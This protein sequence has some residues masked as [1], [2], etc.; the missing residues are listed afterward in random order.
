MT[1]PKEEI[2]RLVPFDPDN[3]VEVETLLQQ[4]IV[5]SA[6]RRLRSPYLTILHSRCLVAMRV[7][8]GYDRDLEGTSSEE[9]QG[10]L[11]C[12]FSRHERIYFLLL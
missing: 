11:R 12:L 5:S 7:G 3:Q 10:K 2:I 8:G 6:C 4:R 9:S 1:A